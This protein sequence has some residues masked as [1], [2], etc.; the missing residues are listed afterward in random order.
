MKTRI[1]IDSGKQ[2][3][4]GAARTALCNRQVLTDATV[5][6]RPDLASNNRITQD[7]DQANCRTCLRRNRG[8]KQ[9]SQNPVRKE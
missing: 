5:A 1:C 8:G 2:P 6:H 3:S 9:H 4:L 7:P